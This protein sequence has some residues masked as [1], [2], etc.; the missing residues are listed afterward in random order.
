MRIVVA[1]NANLAKLAEQGVF[2]MNLL[3]RIKIMHL[4]LP[5]LRQRTGDALL[6]ANHFLQVC[7]KRY[8]LG[9][10]QLHP[11]TIAWLDHY[12]WPGNIRELENMIC[13]EYLLTDTTLIYIKSPVSY[14]YPAERRNGIDRRQSKKI[15]GNFTEAKK[16]I[17]QEFEQCFLVEALKK[18]KVTS[19]WQL[20]WWV[21]NGVPLVN[22]LKNTEW[23]KSFI[24]STNVSK[25]ILT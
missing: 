1:S 15:D 2:R 16:Q 10:K 24:I 12:H 7:A 4:K 18:P 20:N 3:F 11:E 25:F 8:D 22:C 9:E 13:R 6:L 21:R 17:I 23:I 19:P 5:P 14:P